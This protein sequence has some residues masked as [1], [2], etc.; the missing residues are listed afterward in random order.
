MALEDY[1]A[2]A[3]RC[4]QDS[5]CKW[6]PFDQMKSWRF[7]KGC[8]SIAYNNFNSYS[9]RGRYAVTLALLNG[10]ITYNEKLKDIAFQCQTCGTCDVT[11]KICRYN[12]E[13]LDMIRELRA[14]LVSDGQTLPQHKALING[15]KKTDNM[16]LKPRADRGKWA[17]GLEV[18]DLAEKKASVAFH[19]GC[20]F[21]YDEG[22]KTKPVRRF[23]C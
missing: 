9:A 12:L 17:E 16:L 10:R 19:A 5:Y 14:K 23:L 15:L 11:C 4:S 8:P 7:S 3:E 20:R 6:I 1:L 2:E 18:K 13:P 21:S 22:P